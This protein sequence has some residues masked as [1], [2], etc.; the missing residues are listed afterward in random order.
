MEIG[1]KK[2][3]KMIKNIYFP[4]RKL[5]NKLCFQCFKFF[6]LLA[7]LQ[8]LFQQLL[9]YATFHKKEEFGGFFAP[10]LFDT[11]LILTT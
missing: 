5:L 9:N 3:G 10:R 8:S 1:D 4:G 6:I 2:S 7:V 11:E